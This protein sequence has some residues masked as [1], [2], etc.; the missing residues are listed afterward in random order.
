MPEKTSDYTPLGHLRD[1]RYVSSDEIP[2][3]IIHS[4]DE[5][6]NFKVRKSWFAGVV[7]D[8]ENAF[9]RGEIRTPER[10]LA[11]K[12]LMERFTSEEFTQQK[13]TEESD[14]VEAN[15]L[16]DIILEE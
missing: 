10:K 16:I 12:Q 4:I 2:H 6:R 3:K 14:I 5:N 1:L 8:V 9:R 13:L 7:A 15:R 11:A